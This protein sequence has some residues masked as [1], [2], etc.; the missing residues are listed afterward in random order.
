MNARYHDPHGPVCVRCLARTHCRSSQSHGSTTRPSAGSRVSHQTSGA[1]GFTSSDHRG[2]ACQ[3]TQASRTHGAASSTLCTCC[4]AGLDASTAV[5]ADGIEIAG[6]RVCDDQACQK[7][8]QRQRVLQQEPGKHAAADQ[9]QLH[10][11]QQAF[12]H[13]GSV[14]KIGAPVKMEIQRSGSQPQG[15]D[16]GDDN[17]A[18]G[19]TLR[20][21]VR[22]C[23][24]HRPWHQ[25]LH[26]LE[27]H[28]PGASGAR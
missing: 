10:P 21:S 20:V 28:R 25:T 5:R 4:S 26:S 14:R 13:R 19:G 11:M 12:A 6:D 3:P 15:V 8:D 24:S 27:L 9:Q 2:W 18:H 17:R 22:S 23:G 7:R 16:T 1:A